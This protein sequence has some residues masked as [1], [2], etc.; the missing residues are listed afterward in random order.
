MP[1]YEL[2]FW[3]DYRGTHGHEFILQTEENETESE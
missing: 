3:E 2:Q 1:Q